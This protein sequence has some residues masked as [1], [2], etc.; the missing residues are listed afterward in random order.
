MK[1]KNNAFLMNK[2][3]LEENN[4]K[5]TVFIEISVYQESDQVPSKIC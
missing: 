4:I 3:I 1:H 5:Y 2:W